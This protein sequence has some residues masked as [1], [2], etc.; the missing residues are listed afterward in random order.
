MDVAPALV[1]AA[2]ALAI[3]R[4]P[5]AND[6]H[7]EDTHRPVPDNGLGSRNFRG[8]GGSGLWSDVETHLVVRRGGNVDRSCRRR[9]F[10]FWRD[11]MVDRKQKLAIVLFGVVEK[12]ACQIELVVFD[13]RF[14]DGQSLSFE[15]S[16]SHA[17]ADKRGVGN[18]H[19]VFDDFDFVADL[20]ATKNRN[21]RAGGIGQR[22]CPR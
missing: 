22:S 7:F 17:P 11:D 9:G 1:A 14:S 10:K 2:T 13:E 6:G 15:K 18:L 16:V 4:V 21:E 8:E 12:F 19:E 3:S 5:F 20:C